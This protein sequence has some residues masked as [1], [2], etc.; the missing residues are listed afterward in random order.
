MRESRPLLVALLSAT[1][2]LLFALRCEASEGARRPG[3]GSVGPSVKAP[4]TKAPVATGQK[5]PAKGSALLAHG[6]PQ[7]REKIPSR[8][9][10]Q[11]TLFPLE[12]VRLLDGPFKR[13]QETDRAYLLR[14]DPDR[15][16]S[17]IR[18][19]AGLQPKAIPYGGWDR[20]GAGIIGHYLSACSYMAQSTGDPELRR[21]VDYMVSELALAQKANGD[22]GLYS[23]DYDKNV[24]FAKLAQGQV[25]KVNVEAWYVVHKTMAG[26]RDAWLQCGN[27]QARDVLQ[28]MGDWCIAVTAKLTPEQWQQMLEPEHGGPHE[29]LAD[30]YSITGERKYLDCALKFR[31]LKVMDG[32]A[33]NDDTVLYGRH[34][35]SEMA[36]FV[37]YQRIYEM[38]GDKLS[39]DAAR[40]FWNDVVDHHT[41]ANGGNG[42]W[43]HFFNPDTFSKQV[44]EN[45][46]PETCDIYNMLKLTESRFAL[47]PAAADLDYYERALYNGILPSQVPGE[48][49]FVYYTSMRPGHYRTFS[50]DY[51]AFWCC[52]GTGMENHGKYGALIYASQG[53]RLFVNLFIPSALNWRAKGVNVKQETTFPESPRTKLTLQTARPQKLTLSVRYPHWVVA[54]ALQ[55]KVNGVSVPITARPDDYADITR[56]WKNG[57][58]I[59]VELP[60]TKHAEML[61]H[62]TGYTA[63]F[64]GPVMLAGALGTEGLIPEDFSG[65][66]FPGSPADNLATK[67]VNTD[68]APTLIGTPQDALNHLQPVAGEPLTFKLAAG[69]GQKPVTVMPFYRLFLNRYAVY[70]PLADARTFART[71]VRQNDLLLRTVDAVQPGNADQEK[72]HNLQ[73]EGSTTNNMNWRDA[74]GAGGYFSYDLK[75]LADAPQD[76]VITYWGDDG[77]R[78]FDI[79]VN[80]QTIATETLHSEAP[81]QNFERTYPIPPALTTG[82]TKLTVRFQPR[83]GSTAGGVFGVRLLQHSSPLQGIG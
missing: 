6:G 52:V 27:A 9:P 38:S 71:Q 41:W 43:E 78:A 31:H 59:T 65:S 34:A 16:L 48:G 39:G 24:W 15:F 82:K 36:K 70:W 66:S 19:I 57:D 56:V 51:D 11:A 14:L 13:A 4:S 10:Y 77:G 64:Y 20:D 42:Q 1:A 61:P 46:G 23:Y 75:S 72:V 12:D 68:I 3:V 47:Q 80:G 25:L 40:N 62:S 37:A 29:V 50:R 81:G 54:G 60:M 55:I 74:S 28:R 26:L 32:L 35:N 7:A 30:L 83:V 73:S 69:A 79:I 63:L 18:S 8:V 17:H 2:P 67:R 58:Q 22:G 5:S 44:L 21:R 49:G 33:K 76:L 45:C 53:D